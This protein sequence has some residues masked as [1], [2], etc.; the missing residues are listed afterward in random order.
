RRLAQLHRLRDEL[1][2]R[3]ELQ[4]DRRGVDLLR[5]PV[6][7]HLGP[8]ARTV[9]QPADRGSDAGD[10]SE[11]PVPADHRRLPVLGL[12]GVNDQQPTTNAQTAFFWEMDVGRWEFSAV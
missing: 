2:R 1:R 10:E 4:A 9:G 11:R 7:L 3:R 5:S 12:K 8:G 6:S